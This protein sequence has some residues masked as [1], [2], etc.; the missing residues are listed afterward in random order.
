MAMGRKY[1]ETFHLVEAS[2]ARL[3]ATDA[4]ADALFRGT[5]KKFYGL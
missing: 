4:E 3:G 1:D 5:A 2:C